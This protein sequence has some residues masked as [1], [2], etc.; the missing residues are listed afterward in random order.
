MDPLVTP[1]ALAA[2][3]K[4]TDIPRSSAEQAVRIASGAVRAACRWHIAPEIEVVEDTDPDPSGVL[5]LR[6]LRVL[7]V[8]AVEVDGVPWLEADIVGRW[9]RSG[10]LDLG[11]PY[12]GRPPRSLV[13]VTHTSGYD[14][15]PDE[16]AGV[17]LMLA[18]R[19]YSNPDQLTGYTSGSWSPTFGRNS[20]GAGVGIALTR[21]EL[22]LLDEYVRP[23]RA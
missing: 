8:T 10:L 22:A 9:T 15:T 5:H 1:E 7:E 3:I 12:G 2:Y 4:Q 6:S 23:V 21:P 14:D 20:D 17:V 18:A 11:C 19:A 16:V 13:K